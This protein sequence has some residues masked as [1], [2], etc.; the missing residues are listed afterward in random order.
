MF[1]EPRN[2]DHGLSR[3]PF[4]SIII[5]RPIGWISSID[6]ESV[7]NLAPFSF[8]NAVSEEPPIVM[9]SCGSSLE[10][11]GKKDTL[12][13]VE[14]TREFVCNVATWDL[15]EQMNE[16]SARLNPKVDELTE[17]ELTAIPSILIKPSRVA[18]AP[19]HLECKHI[20]SIEL[21]YLSESNRNVIVLGEVIG[22]HII[23]ELIMENGLI[24]VDRLSAIGRLG[25][26]DY[27]RIGK[28]NT[29]SMTRPD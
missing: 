14:L 7:G 1:Y 17:A 20:K 8:F 11:D 23:D 26:T 22:I 9:F 6:G 16:S 15:R 4:K 24:N 28:G 21:P 3:N 5:P 2:H 18:E 12:R 25:Y 27:V 13:N 19:I 29:F 10:K